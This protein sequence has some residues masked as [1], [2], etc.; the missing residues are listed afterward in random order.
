MEWKATMMSLLVCLEIA[1]NTAMHPANK[2]IL[3]QGIGLKIKSKV[4][5]EIRHTLPC[6]AQLYFDNF[7]LKLSLLLKRLL[8]NKLSN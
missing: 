8:I 1:V 6:K 7:D 3:A 2:S 4:K 5:F